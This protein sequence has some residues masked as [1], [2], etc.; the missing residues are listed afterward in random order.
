[1]SQITQTDGSWVKEGQETLTYY[2]KGEKSE[3]RGKKPILSN[4]LLNIILWYINVKI[5]FKKNNEG[6]IFE[7]S[8]LRW[9]LCLKIKDQSFAHACLSDGWGQIFVLK[10]IEL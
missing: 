1:M 10:E 6:L 5:I 7:S 2:F 3:L 9:R 4:L 8:Y